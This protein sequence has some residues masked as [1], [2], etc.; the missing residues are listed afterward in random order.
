MLFAINFFAFSPS[1]ASLNLP[2]HFVFFLGFLSYSYTS[3]YQGGSPL[4]PIPMR[5]VIKET[6]IDNPE[7]KEREASHR[8]GDKK[9]N[10]E[11]EVRAE[12]WKMT[13]RHSKIRPEY[14]QHLYNDHFKRSVNYFCLICSFER[15]L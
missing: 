7:E 4:N 8:I 9:E 11:R 6:E 15:S 10:W 2:N 12:R 3:Q 13:G 14:T 5:E 1:V